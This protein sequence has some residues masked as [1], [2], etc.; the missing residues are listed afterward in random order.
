VRRKARFHRT[1]VSVE[2]A[3]PYAAG[4]EATDGWPGR[5]WLLDLALALALT[6]VTVASLLTPDPSVRYEQPEPD[7]RLVLLALAAGL[8]LAWR[9]RRPVAVL[10][11]V[12]VAHTAI[13]LLGWDPD[14]VGVCLLFALYAV[15]AWR[16]LRVSAAAL[17]LVHAVLAAMYVLTDLPSYAGGP[18]LPEDAVFVVV[19]L[20]G[21]FMRWHR[22]GEKTATSRVLE[23]ERTRA[24]NAE[25]AMLAERFRI[26]RELHD[27]ITHTLSAIAVQSSV[28]RHLVDTEPERAGPA[29]AAIE[30]AGRAALDD[31]R[32]MLTLLR[33]TQPNQPPNR[34]KDPD[35]MAGRLWLLDL[36]LG[37]AMAAV[38]VGS[39]LSAD[40]TDAYDY[41]EPA[42]ALVLLAVAA[43]LPLAV[44]RRWPLPAH[45]MITCAGGVIA[46]LSWNVGAVPFCMMLSLYTVAA[47]R[48]WAA[49]AGSLL[50]TYAGMGVLAVL[51]A[52]YF[53]HPLA[54]VA[55][56]SFTT[57][58]AFGRYA[59]H[60]RHAWARP[61]AVPVM[62]TDT[63]YRKDPEAERQPTVGRSPKRLAYLLRP[64]G[65]PAA[66]RCRAYTAQVVAAVNRVS[67]E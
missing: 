38:T 5:E 29:L 15:A 33:A 60:R 16:P 49:A 48:P 59:R 66:V 46:G 3:V 50:L 44:R 25:R 35:P 28:A 19:W 63:S 34:E 39:V 11:V 9:R 57:V 6:A 10:A 23:A 17:I 64:S 8:A 62:S 53:D 18:S 52:P 20:L 65:Q 2:I 37:V 42:P 31:L 54:L 55:V 43:S 58:W 24:L 41:P 4:V 12:L 61:P 22:L 45:A 67:D 40:P 51:G 7:V 56:A 26:A 27:V 32:R 21:W 30:T 36:L 14:L 47:W 13:E 1:A